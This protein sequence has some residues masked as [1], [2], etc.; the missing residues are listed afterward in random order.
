MRT[1]LVQIKRAVFLWVKRVCLT[2]LRK[3]DPSFVLNLPGPTNRVVSLPAAQHN[4]SFADHGQTLVV[5]EGDLVTH[6][7]HLTELIKAIFHQ[8]TLDEKAQALLNEVFSQF[9]NQTVSF[10]Q[11]VKFL[12]EKTFDK[13]KAEG[14]EGLYWTHVYEKIKQHEA[15]TKANQQAYTPAAYANP[16]AVFWPDPTFK[17]KRSLFTEIPYAKKFALVDRQAA[18]GSAGSCFAIEIALWLQRNGYN[19]IITENDPHPTEGQYSKSCAR[20]GIIF[21]T[22]SFRQLVEK[23]FGERQLPKLLWSLKGPQGVQLMDPFREDVIFNSVEEYEKDLPQHLEACRKAL[24]T[25]DYFVLTLGVN[26]VWRLKSD[27]SVFSRAPWRISSH[28]VE[29]K[30]MSVEDNLEELDRMVKVWRKYNP[31]VKFI[32]TVSPVPLHA[33]F[34][35]NEHHVV[36]ANAHSKAS[37]RVV[38]EE[39]CKRYDGVYYFPSYESVMYC[40]ENAWEADQRHVSRRAVDKVM[41]LFETMFLK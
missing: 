15:M 12:R 29:H 17:D 6:A 18:I 22:P 25:C 3:V 5:N 9:Q 33:T 39:F 35:A 7:E 34:R 26:E 20:W 40:T 41:N 2:V 30:V 37:L 23:A 32:V 36:T 27:G 13:M 19:Y 4:F 14:E 16:Q 31:K 10:D 38:A 1:V 21:N 28:L 11:V 8:E 24:A